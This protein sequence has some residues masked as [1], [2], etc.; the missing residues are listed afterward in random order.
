MVNNLVKLD[1]K[2]I[3]YINMN[4]KCKTLDRIMKLI[5]NMG[6]CGFVW[7]IISLF[8]I[9]NGNNKRLGVL[10]LLSLILTTIIGEIIIK[11]IVKRER[12]FKKLSNE[13]QLLIQKP[14]TYSFP[15]GHSGSSFAVSTVFLNLAGRSSIAVLMLA[16]LIALSRVYLN[17]HYPTDVIAGILLGFLCGIIILLICV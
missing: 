8:I 2:I 15:S 10:S 1:L 17:V 9:Y 5:T 12:P 13:Y 3:E 6:N 16:L 4:I 7:I 11:N 14:K